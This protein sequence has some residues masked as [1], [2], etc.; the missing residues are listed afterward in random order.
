MEENRDLVF[1]RDRLYTKKVKRLL[2]WKKDFIKNWWDTSYAEYISGNDFSERDLIPLFDVYKK[3]LLERSRLS[4]NLLKK[5]SLDS[6]LS[7]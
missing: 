5:G 6:E 7:R 4:E 1:E 2:A 3:Y